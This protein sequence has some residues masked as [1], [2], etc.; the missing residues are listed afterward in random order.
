MSLVLSCQ[1][2]LYVYILSLVASSSNADD[3]LQET[4]AVMWRKFNQF[5]AGTNFLAWGKTIARFIILDFLRKNRNKMVQ[6]DSDVL[7]LIESKSEKIKN[8][9]DQTEILKECIKKLT[10]RQLALVKMRYAKDMS[11]KKIAVEFGISKQRT[12][13]LI[14]RIHALLT[15]CVKSNL[16]R[17]N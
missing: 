9:S 7:K 13:S 15:N 2:D 5:E 3:I 14:S 8:I 6:F 1:K 10:E 16:I 17:G 11:F 12:Y 4:L